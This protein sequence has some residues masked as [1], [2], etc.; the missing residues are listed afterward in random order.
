MPYA[1]GT[2]TLPDDPV[3]IDEFGEESSPVVQS[4]SF[5]STGSQFLEEAIKQA[6]T[7]MT[8]DL[9][10]LT[11]TQ[12]LSLKA[13]A[14]IANTSYALLIPQGSFTVAFRR[15]PYVVRPIRQLADPDGADFYQVTVNLWTV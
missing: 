7:P 5:G 14:D 2:L 3:W 15:P 11:R 4:Q 10:W 13:L 8:L 6:G 9:G 1:L 12:M